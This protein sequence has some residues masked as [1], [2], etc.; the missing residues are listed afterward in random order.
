MIISL[1]RDYDF[2]Y[3][4]SSSSFQSTNWVSGKDERGQKFEVLNQIITM[5]ICS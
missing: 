2:K 4:L 3:L 5:K 1:L